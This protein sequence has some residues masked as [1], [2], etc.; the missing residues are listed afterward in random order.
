MSPT[1][2]ST[3]SSDALTRNLDE[4]VRSERGN[5]VEQLWHLTEMERRKTHLALGYGS[6]FKYCQERLKL[7]NA[8]CFRRATAARLVS[9][10]PVACDYLA[11]GRLTLTTLVELRD[12]LDDDNH[13]ELLQR[14]AGC[15][16]DQVKLL[17]ATLQPR[18][19][20][21]ETIRAVPVR[22]VE[23]PPAP[24]TSG[25]E[26][27]PPPSPVSSGPEL[28]VRVAMPPP[29]PRIEPVSATRYSVH[30]TVSAEFRDELDR[31]KDALSHVI[32]SRDTEAVLRECMRIALEKVARRKHAATRRPANA[33][34]SSGPELTPAASSRSIPARVRRAVNERDEGRCA[35]RAGDGRRCNSTHQLEYHHE[36]P[37]ARGGP[38]TVENLSL[39]CKRHNH[40][41]AMLDFGAEHM[42]QFSRSG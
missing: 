41:E 17:V 5:I 2:L 3:V 11:D 7:S 21:R 26:L 28:A 15:T 4:L 13:R 12:V 34:P 33:A 18:P 22:Q 9:R 29:P 42:A 36:H 19:E 40:Y 25:P 38:P 23:V 32:P 8:C 16:E 37:Y 1:D 6:L 27:A 39:R 24:V 30:L 10:F 31:V 35:F 20:T 14:A